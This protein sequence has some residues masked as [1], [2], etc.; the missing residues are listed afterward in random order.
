M[1]A[2]L[3]LVLGS[4]SPRR[5]ELLASIGLPHE[6]CPAQVEEPQPG[7]LPPY[8]LVAASAR[9]KTR[10]VAAR[11][12]GRLVLGADTI[13]VVGDS[14]QDGEVLGK[15]AGAGQA[16]EMLRLLAGKAHRVLTSV[17][18]IGE[19]GEAEA[20]S[21][22]AV[23]FEPLDRDF[24][25]RYVVTGEPL[26]KAGSYGAQGFMGT[27]VRSISGSWTNVVG[28]PLELLPGLFAKLG[29]SLADWQDW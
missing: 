15:P 16:R 5:T 26:D 7:S 2:R 6:V 25:E 14:P 24:I 8:E 17:V 10:T 20:T 12:P 4:A 27:Q 18:L 19:E 28:L 22:T 9:L 23:S 13:V 29:E 21:T 1:R 3:P 11:M